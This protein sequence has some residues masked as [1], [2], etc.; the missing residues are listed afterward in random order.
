MPIG[1]SAAKAFHPRPLDRGAH[2]LPRHA[3]TY[4]S[5]LGRQLEIVSKVL[6]HHSN[7][8]TTQQYL[9][10]ISDADAMG[11]IKIFTENK[12]HNRAED[13]F[14]PGH[15]KKSGPASVMIWIVLKF[16]IR[17]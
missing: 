7:H 13:K 11:L 10:K 2:D 4:V 17:E 8:S 12:T 14:Q 6:L 1:K 15:F 16:L 9:G 5:R 3:A